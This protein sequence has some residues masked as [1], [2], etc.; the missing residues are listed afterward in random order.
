LKYNI[1]LW[2]YIEKYTSQK[3]FIKDIDRLKYFGE[4]LDIS[5]VS[6]VQ[7]LKDIN[8]NKFRLDEHISK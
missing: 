4:L 5:E 2:E 1:L 7:Y 3:Y 6:I 8:N